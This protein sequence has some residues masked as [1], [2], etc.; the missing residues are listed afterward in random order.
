V[1]GIADAREVHRQARGRWAVDGS[2]EGEREQLEVQGAHPV[3][4]RAEDPRAALEE[5]GQGPWRI[6]RAIG[7]GPRRLERHVRS[8]PVPAV[9]AQYHLHRRERPCHLR[10]VARLSG[11]GG[12]LVRGGDGDGVIAAEVFELDLTPQGG[13]EDGRIGERARTRDDGL[14]GGA[15]LLDPADLSQRG[16][17]PELRA[18]RRDLGDR[19]RVVGRREGLA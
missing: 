2:I 11:D 17:A 9:V 4:A 12:G 10:V 3:V 14:C 18:Q 13:R 5:E 19:L 8:L 1:E 15:A 16:D 6:A 7:R